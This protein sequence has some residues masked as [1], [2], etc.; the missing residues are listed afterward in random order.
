MIGSC[1]RCDFTGEL[2]RRDLCPACYQ[3]LWRAGALPKLTRAP[4]AL[5]VTRDCEHPG[6]PHRH[7]TRVA[8]VIDR[9]RC[10]P[11]TAANHHRKADAA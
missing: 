3:Q 1:T 11:C 9:C 6:H 8:Y 4:R 5:R 7:G 2:R 10:E